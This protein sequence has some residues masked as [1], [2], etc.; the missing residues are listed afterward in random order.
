MCFDTANRDLSPRL[1]IKRNGV[2]L[3]TRILLTRIGA[4]GTNTCGE[5][6]REG[7]VELCE[8]PCAHNYAIFVVSLHARKERKM[9]R[10][11]SPVVTYQIISIGFDP[12]DRSEPPAPCLEQDS[13]NPLVSR[14]SP[15]RW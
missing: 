1:Q 13:I 11:L 6:R 7:F 15:S 5:G 8:E 2:C 12:N 10:Q 3:L 9:I 4:A 14:T